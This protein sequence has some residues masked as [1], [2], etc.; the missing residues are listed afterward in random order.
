M[1][2][3]KTEGPG[4]LHTRSFSHKKGLYALGLIEKEIFFIYFFSLIYKY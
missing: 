3:I 4:K 2:V 1:T